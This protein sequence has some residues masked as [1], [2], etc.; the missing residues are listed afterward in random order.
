M[1]K[2][3]VDEALAGLGAAHDRIAA[4]MFAIDSHTG[5]AFLRGGG[6]TG[7]TRARWDTLKAELDLLWAHFAL[8][9][10]LLEKAREIRN[11]R[12]LEDADWATLRLLC[13]DPVVSL[14]PTGLPVGLGSTGGPVGLGSTALPASAGNAPPVTRLRLWDLAG[15]LERRCGAVT[16]Q[17]SDVDSA[18]SVLAGRYAPLTQEIDALVGQARGVG[19]DELAEPLAKA[20]SDAADT[21]LTDPLGAAPGGGQVS[22]AVQGRLDEMARRAATVRERVSALVEVRDGYQRQAAEL[23]ALLDQVAS[24]EERLGVAYAR[25]TQKIA[26]TGLPPRPASVAVLRVRLAELDGLFRACRWSQ[27][28]DGAAA[29]EQAAVRARARADELR[30]AADG[31]VARRDELRGRLEAY[32]AKA[33][34]LGYAE[35]DELTAVHSRAREL[36]YTAPCDLP[37]ATRAVFAY[38]QALAALPRATPARNDI[39]D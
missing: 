10:D 16:A 6:L 26:D 11:R 4:A 31:L 30:E 18:W 27:L 33:A 34:R 28:A 23:R 19:L 7:Q 36:L 5:L 20:L 38:Q 13:N 21:D 24:A 8:L 32:R 37:G 9:G 15:Q 22:P 39:D 29:I 35:H 3:S 14:D 25:A 2:E 12:R 1:S 17:L